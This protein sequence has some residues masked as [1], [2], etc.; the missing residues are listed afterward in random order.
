MRWTQLDPVAGQ[1]SNPLTLNAYQYASCDPVNVVDPSGRF[2]AVRG[3]VG[4][5]LVPREGVGGFAGPI[6]AVKG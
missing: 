1:L 4:G 3:R 6:A 5:A 2:E